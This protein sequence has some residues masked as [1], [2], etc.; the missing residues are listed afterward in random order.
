[1]KIKV[2]LILL[3]V[4]FTS[5]T[6]KSDTQVP[7]APDAPFKFKVCV[8]VKP[9]D[10]TDLDERLEAF[11]RRELRALGDVD[12]VKRDADWHYFLAY[13]FLEN[14]LKNGTKTG[15]LSI[16]HALMA[17]HPDVAHKTYRFPEL[18]KPAMFEGISAAHWD[19]DSLHEL[20][21][22]SIGNFDKEI[23]E[24]VRPK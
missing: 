23:L 5:I 18:G 3:A 13:D 17:F 9:H 19:A 8:Y 10:D 21:I 2:F 7:I 15:W 20:A 22:Q 14:T 24:R 11:L 4:I 1:M 16:A 12:I 6:L